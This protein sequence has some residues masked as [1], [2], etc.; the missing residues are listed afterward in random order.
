MSGVE[1]WCIFDKVSPAKALCQPHIL[2]PSAQL[3]SHCPLY[4][5]LA[6]AQGPTITLTTVPA[7]VQ[8]TK[9]GELAPKYEAQVESI[10]DATHI[11]LGS[12]GKLVA[13]GAGDDLI[14]MR[15]KGII[16]NASTKLIAK[17]TL[18]SPIHYLEVSGEDKVLVLTKAGNV[19]VASGGQKRDLQY[20]SV[21]S[22]CFSIT[23]KELVLA[24]PGS[25]VLLSCADFS[26]LQT[27]STNLS[28]QII[29][30]RHITPDF[31][32][33]MGIDTDKNTECFVL[34]HTF[35]TGQKFEDSISYHQGDDGSLNPLR[36]P[37]G[38]DL[39][40]LHCAYIQSLPERD[41]FLFCSTISTTVEVVYMQE[42]SQTYA[43]FETET[44]KIKGPLGFLVKENR[45]F[46]MLC[47]GL[48]LVKSTWEAGRFTYHYIDEDYDLPSQPLVLAVGMTGELVSLRLVD[49]REQ[50]QQLETTKAPRPLQAI[51][52]FAVSPS[53][54]AVND[55]NQREEAKA[56]KV[57]EVK[58]IFS[59]FKLGESKPGTSI[60][61]PNPSKEEAKSVPLA[62]F[63]LPTG[64][65][66][67]VSQ[68][69][70]PKPNSSLFAASVE[71]RKEEG[72]VAAK[73]SVFDTAKTS[74]IKPASGVFSSVSQTKE[75][76]KLP[77]KA[78]N[79]ELQ[80]K[81]EG[82]VAKS[83]FF[84]ASPAPSLSSLVSNPGPDSFEKQESAL[85]QY[86]HSQLQDLT[87]SLT[88][89]QELTT[90][91]VL[92]VS[93]TSA[94]TIK[95]KDL[96]NA[97]ETH[98]SALERLNGPLRKLQQEEAC[99]KLEFESLKQIKRQGLLHS[100]DSLLPAKMGKKLQIMEKRVI[101][102]QEYEIAFKALYEQQNTRLESLLGPK[103]TVIRLNSGPR[104]LS[105]F[106]APQ[107]SS[108][109]AVVSTHKAANLLVSAVETI[110]QRLLTVASKLT[111]YQEKFR[112]KRQEK[113]FDFNEVD[114]IELSEDEEDIRTEEKVAYKPADA[115]RDFV[116]AVNRAKREKRE[117]AKEKTASSLS[118]LLRTP[119]E[120][121]KGRL[122]VK[123]VQPLKIDFKVAAGPTQTVSAQLEQFAALVKEIRTGKAAEGGTGSNPPF[124]PAAA[125]KQ[126]PAAAL[127][128]KGDATES[129][130]GV[131]APAQ[132]KTEAKTGFFA[133][134]TE[135]K[136]AAEPKPSPVT[137]QP[138]FF[139]ATAPPASSLFATPKEGTAAKPTPSPVQS[140][141][142][143][144][145]AQS[146]SAFFVSAKPGTEAKSMFSSFSPTPAASGGTAGFGALS[147]F[148]K[149]S[150]PTALGGF[151]TAQQ[152]GGFKAVMEASSTSFAMFQNTQ[153]T[154]NFVQGQAP[155]FPQTAPAPT[156]NSDLFKPRK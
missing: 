96:R 32:A 47:R 36:P 51:P 59:A 67:P 13:V 82:Q 35:F 99:N 127:E 28:S 68:K 57:E 3:L 150:I 94:F 130:S 148:S 138:G 120:K 14:L 45:R 107:K 93:C 115:Q 74:E 88:R 111:L 122:S 9:G 15:T 62:K 119:S 129:K 102:L 21:Q 118:P 50:Y 110:R 87:D 55:S 49:L 5:L 31:W 135:V 139:P 61:A 63:S 149:P 18:A 78:G 133:A 101:L 24:L 54:P 38:Y 34:R 132:G 71:P 69:S 29:G 98:K 142:N 10:H 155:A 117:E 41:C 153:T 105:R 58:G 43:R 12:S 77:A 26:V 116:E 83:A 53:N 16:D 60:F 113:R 124:G 73:A 106:S 23:D 1:D 22:C 146:T 90:S 152:A 33:F 121:D 37:Q 126:G 65:L 109:S 44:A 125:Q 20:G 151:S 56:P 76:A 86:V 80:G 85:Y 114:N 143:P 27:C 2:N 128:R 52:D 156:G 79:R 64:N 70:G 100:L 6:F 30:I 11:V 136:P 48:V 81:E 75:E 112:P 131:L 4:G 123:Q 66:E 103:S 144:Q 17:M 25:F 104:A 91:P 42:D 145:P 72:T 40:A 92:T 95:V 140:A 8:W 84:A 19:A 97:V 154:S 7:L 141:F 39:T 137:P 89:L 108:P 134:K 147:S 46:D